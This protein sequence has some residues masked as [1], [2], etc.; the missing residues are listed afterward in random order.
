MI[1]VLTAVT[2][3]LAKGISIEEFISK[4]ENRYKY[5]SIFY[6][7]FY[8]F[9]RTI[10]CLCAVI[11]PF[12]IGKQ[13]LITYSTS[14]SIV[15]AALVGLDLVLKP[16]DNWKKYSKSHIDLELKQIDTKKATKEQLAALQIIQ[17]TE[18]GKE[19][20]ISMEELLNTVKK[21]DKNSA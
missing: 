4:W 12:I 17:K 3:S 14:C 6:R 8:Y 19:N 21:A 11:L 2:S 5:Y 10:T 13:S 7:F 1:D 15:I 18:N 9:S 16:K 20:L